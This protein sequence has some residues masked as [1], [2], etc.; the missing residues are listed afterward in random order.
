MSRAPVDASAM[1]VSTRETRRWV[2]RRNRAPGMRA[3]PL[4][5]VDP[6]S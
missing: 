6:P 2:Q 5:G 4:D 3:T 1:V